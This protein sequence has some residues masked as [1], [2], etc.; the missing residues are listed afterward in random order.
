[1]SNSFSRKKSYSNNFEKKSLFLGEK[2][3]DLAYGTGTTDQKFSSMQSKIP[4]NTDAFFA[5]AGMSYKDLGK[6]EYLPY[7]LILLNRIR[8]HNIN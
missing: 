1:M 8:T 6:I 2:I 5:A 3:Y 7:Q 4:N